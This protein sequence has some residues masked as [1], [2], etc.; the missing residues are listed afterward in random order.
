MRVA[1]LHPDLGIGGAERLIVDAALGL[2]KRGHQV[3]IYTSYHDPDHC[4]DE[5]RDGTLNVYHIVPPFPRSINGKGHILFA[6]L[7]QLHLTLH[8]LRFPSQFGKKRLAE[9]YDIFFIDQLST[10]IP[11]LQRFA[12]RR[13]VF[14]G[15]FPDKL[16]AEGPFIENAPKAPTLTLKT[17]YRLPMDWIEDTTTRQADIL[18]FNS[19]FTARVFKNYMSGL[20]KT[21][22]V[23]YPGINTETYDEP[24]P[25]SLMSKNPDYIQEGRSLVGDVF[26]FR[27]TLVSLNRF[28][29][30]KNANLAINAFAEVIKQLDAS[31]QTKPLERLR[32]VLA[33]GFDPRLKDNIVT[34]KSLIDTCEE[35]SLTYRITPL[36]AIESIKDSEPKFRNLSNTTDEDPDIVFL[37]NF[38]RLQRNYLLKSPNTLALLYTPT[39]EHFGIIPVEGMLSRLPV[40][41]CDSGGP[42][43]SVLDPVVRE[44]V[45]EK[46]RTGWLRPPDPNAWAD[47]IL[48]ILNMSKAERAL[49]GDRARKR[50]IEM[51]GLSAMAESIENALQEAINL[52]PIGQDT[53]FYWRLSATEWRDLNKGLFAEL[54]LTS[55]DDFVASVICDTILTLTSSFQGNANLREYI[56]LSVVDPHIPVQ[57]YQL[58]SV[59]LRMSRPLSIHEPSNLDMICR[60]ILILH[61]DSHMP[62]SGSLVPYSAPPAELLSTIS[63]SLSLL[64]LSYDFPTSPFHQL[65]TSAAELVILLF[66]CVE[67]LSSLVVSTSQ[68]SFLLSQ[69]HEVLQVIPLGANIRHS[70]DSFLLA[71]SLLLNEGFRPVEE[72]QV[73]TN[74]QLTPRPDANES[75]LSMDL[76]TGTLIMNRLVADR[77][78]PSGSGTEKIAVANLIAWF[79]VSSHSLGI[80]Y[81]HVLLSVLSCLSQTSVELD[82]NLNHLWKSFL[83]GRCH[84]S[85]FLLDTG[86]I[87]KIS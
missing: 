68:V 84:G 7:R 67:N 51:F 64:R 13:V 54:C 4:F 75:N 24:L 38:S 50:A 37:L 33:G 78:L 52:G 44:D 26:S 22:R 9:D 12:Y 62:A 43:E 74:F 80:F 36:T 83:I 57:L 66:S 3:H 41:A 58:L 49:L 76:L 31:N 32:L 79:R 73:F 6:H 82:A 60:L 21:S 42:T 47:A 45:E 16:L 40:I 69:V 70:L 19:K 10:A 20:R 28:E 27:P 8:L 15:H 14:Y 5:T 53:H 59:F 1:F 72:T 25:V 86:L 87:T 11:F 71:L 48:T 56:R 39:N 77:A 85:R 17:L 18:L 2:Q 29:K 55:G 30:K 63:N 61:Y 23:V 65:P 81:A 35:N 34:L 46:E